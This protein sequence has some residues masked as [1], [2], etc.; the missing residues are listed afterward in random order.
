MKFYRKTR[1]AASL[2][3]TAAF[4]R[5]SRALKALTPPPVFVQLRHVEPLAEGSRLDFTLW[6]GPLPV[7]W[8]ALHSEVDPLRGFTDTQAQ[9][10]FERWAHRHTF[11]PVT[12]DITDVVDEIQAEFGRGLY[13][14]LVSRLMWWGLPALFAY[15][16]WA[17]RRNVK[18]REKSGR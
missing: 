12:A 6:I 16:G 9:G 13:K 5:G 8:S 10:P 4:H 17:T 18:G 11:E 3:A 1:L 7:R 2:E 15:R 14:G